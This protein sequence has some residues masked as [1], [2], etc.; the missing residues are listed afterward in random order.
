MH[1]ND[2]FMIVREIRQHV[3]L[4]HFSISGGAWCPPPPPGG[5]GGVQT[6]IWLS[7]VCP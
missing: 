3:D 1:I 4:E 5:G 7:T 6:L 2:H